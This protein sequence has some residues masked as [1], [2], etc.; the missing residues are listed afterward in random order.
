[1]FYSYRLL[2]M[3]RK[4]R[5]ARLRPDPAASF[6]DCLLRFKSERGQGERDVP[7]KKLRN[8]AVR[9][10]IWMKVDSSRVALNRV[11]IAEADP[12]KRRNKKENRANESATVVR[13][14][15]SSALPSDEIVG[16]RD[17][18]VCRRVTEC[19]FE[20]SS[21]PSPTEI[22]QRAR[23]EETSATNRNGDDDDDDDDDD[24]VDDDVRRDSFV[25]CRGAH[26]RR[27]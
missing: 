12:W 27:N 25:S 23:I 6:G 21:Q 20:V 5:S 18:P 19:R 11:D 10:G 14:L 17:F 24:G 3:N 8:Y 2:S 4:T 26:A 7:R 16:N 15:L 22:G 1:M 9:E 13:N